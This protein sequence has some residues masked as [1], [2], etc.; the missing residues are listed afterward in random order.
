MGPFLW[1]LSWST[2]HVTVVSN[3]VNIAKNGQSELIQIEIA[4]LYF[5]LQYNTC[6]FMN[7]MNLHFNAFLLLNEFTIWKPAKNRSNHSSL[8]NLIH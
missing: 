4:S 2:A 8:A 6:R 7:L 1:K 5:N 3:G